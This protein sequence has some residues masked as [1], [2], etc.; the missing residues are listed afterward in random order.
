[1]LHLLDSQERCFFRDCFPGHFTASALVVSADGGRALLAL[2]RFLNR[3]LQFGGHCDGEEDVPAVAR[4]E[5]EEESGI[6]GL[7]MARGE[8]FDLDIHPIPENPDRG[9]PAHL[10]YDIRFLMVAPEGAQPVASAESH[11]VEWFTAQKMAFMAL[12]EGTRRMV[13]K[14]QGLVSARA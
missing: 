1:M 14:W 3:W 11:A 5:A 9:E 2:H 10:H 6:V 12:D 8:P 7:V 13:G 4:R